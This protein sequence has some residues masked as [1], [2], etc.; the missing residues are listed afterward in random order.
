MKVVGFIFRVWGW[1]RVESKRAEYV[2]GE[3][4]VCWTEGGDADWTDRRDDR[5][6]EETIIIGRVV[7]IRGGFIVVVVVVVAVVV[8][9]IIVVVVVF[10]SIVVVTLI[11]LDVVGVMEV[12]MVVSVRGVIVWE[13][14]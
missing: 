4:V 14:G 7:G 9:I 5:M 12:V 6:M 3:G 2:D 10:I 11:E 8:F 13:E 1:V